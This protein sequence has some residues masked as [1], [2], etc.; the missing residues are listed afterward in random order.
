V[1]LKHGDE[2]C[3]FPAIQAGYAA[4]TVDAWQWCSVG[5]LARELQISPPEARALLLALE[6][7]GYLT[8]YTG[9]LPDGHHGAWLADEEDGAEPLVLWHLTSPDGMQLAKAHTGSPISRAVAEALLEGFLDRVRTVNRDPHAT[10]IIESALLYG[11]LADP[12]REEVTDVDLIVYTR[13]RRRDAIGDRPAG[14]SGRGSASVPRWPS[15]EQV[16]TERA[17]LHTLLGASHDRLD[18]AVVDELSD[19]QSLLPPGSIQKG[20]FP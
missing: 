11:S 19:D 3:G 10:H 1:L 13:R 15:E 12:G 16:L 4:R 14:A 5:V 8:R 2:I 9:V 7:G 18:I 6:G 20:V 17:A